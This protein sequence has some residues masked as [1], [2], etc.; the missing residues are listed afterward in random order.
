MDPVTAITLAGTIFQFVEYGGKFVGSTWRLYQKGATDA[1]NPEHLL[2]ISEDLVNLIPKLQYS[3]GN[4][5]TDA[6][7]EESRGFQELAIDCKRT[8]ERVV[9]LLQSLESAAASRRRRGAI[10]AAFQSYSRRTS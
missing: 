10:K 3:E 6:I 4:R 2:G 7:E 9:H 8:A 1:G 5:K